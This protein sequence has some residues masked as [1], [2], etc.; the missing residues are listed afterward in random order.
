LSEQ[1]SS[2]RQIIKAT[3]LFGGVQVFKIIIT[4]IKSKVIAML[5][6]PSGMGIASLLTSTTGL[7]K[8][9]TSFGLGTSAV[10]DI[11][12]AREE[13]NKDKISKTVIV[14]RRL[15]W[16]TGLL[17]LLITAILAPYLSEITFGNR[18]YTTA[19]IWLSL[20]LLFQQLT[21]GQLVLLKGLR[22]LKKLSLANIVGSTAGLIVSIPLYYYFRLDGIVPAIILS[23]ITIFIAS[24]YYNK[25]EKFTNQKVSKKETVVLGKGMLK[26]GFML[27]ITAIVSLGSAYVLRIY[28][29]SIGGL[30]EVGLYNAGFA[31][32]TSYVGLI[33]T[34]MG[35]DYYPRLSGIASDN[36]KSA[37]LINQQAEISVLII[38]PILCIF[39]VFVNSIVVLLY[40]AKFTGINEMIHWAALGMYFKAVSWAISLILLAKGAS[41]VFF[42]NE[43]IASIYMLGLNVLGYLYMGLD[44]L[45]LSFLISYVLYLL[46]VTVLSRKLYDFKFTSSFKKVFIIQIIIG[47]ACFSA[48][49]LIT[50]TYSLWIGI[51]LILIACWYSFRQLDKRIQLKSTISN[52]INSRRK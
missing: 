23:G 17:G 48:I 52:F 38:A 7:I 19:F 37:T 10:R 25:D 21:S 31:I 2:Y 5:L 24:K 32:V 39:F 18:D 22:R 49:K 12:E 9:I 15:I 34:A 44:G 45:G 6:G 1:Q 50:G 3:S 46:Q 47:V 16:G 42:W 14:F 33:F 41:K 36:K 4:V 27:S 51:A 40:S 43:L 35:T 11:S 28:I 20:S 29:N 8:T 30:D 26:M 13:D